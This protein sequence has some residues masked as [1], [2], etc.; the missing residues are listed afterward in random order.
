MASSRSRLAL[1]GAGL[2]YV[3]VLVLIP[4]IAVTWR[5]VSGGVG[6]FWT[7]ITAP[8]ALV[9]FRLTAEVAILAVILNLLFG[10]GMATLLTRYRFRG[11]RLLGMLTDLPI[12]VSPIV[13][14]LALILVYGP[15]DGWFGPGLATAGISVIFSIP[16]MVLATAFV[17]L[18]LILREVAPVLIQ[19]GTDQEEAARVLGANAWQT[20][21]RITLPTIR[22]ALFYGI[23]LCLARCIGEF[24]AV[25]VVSGGVSGDGQTQTVP[26]LVAERVEQFEPGSYQLSFVLVLVTILAILAVSHHRKGTLR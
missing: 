16:G 10:V 18:P 13:V 14:G 20:W 4:L 11:R 12:S 23:V 25:R 19:E 22:P 1:R 24:G 6:Q 2:A 21:W 17:S 8:E 26:L 15:V 5:T 7:S 9:A 3:G